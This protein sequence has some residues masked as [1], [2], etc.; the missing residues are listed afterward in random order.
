MRWIAAFLAAMVGTCL[1]LAYGW[2]LNPVGVADT[3]PASLRIDYRTDYVLMVAEAYRS[4]HDVEF[5]DQQ[6]AIFRG[7]APAETAAAAAQ[8]AR[9]APYAPDDLA[10]LD[11]L[12]RAIGSAKEPSP[13]GNASP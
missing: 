4:T 7:Q 2:I 11:D 8:Q 1:G 10:A 6:L 9:L 5:A 3:T 13:S 12:A